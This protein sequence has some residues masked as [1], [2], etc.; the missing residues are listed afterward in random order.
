MFEQWRKHNCSCLN[1][2]MYAQATMHKYLV[3]TD[4]DKDSGVIPQQS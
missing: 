4:E 3:E 1:P 2:Q